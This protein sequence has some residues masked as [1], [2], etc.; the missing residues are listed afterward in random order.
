MP[1]FRAERVRTARFHVGGSRPLV[2]PVE[3]DLPIFGKKSDRVFLLPS[4]CEVSH[5]GSV[6][7]DGHFLPCKSSV[8]RLRDNLHVNAHRNIASE[9]AE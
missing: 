8:P 9:G 7:Q 1:R 2:Q 4:H 3:A 5:L 6:R